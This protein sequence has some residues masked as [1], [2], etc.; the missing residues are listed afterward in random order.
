M[1]EKYFV[2]IIKSKK[3]GKN[4]IGSTKNVKRRLEWHNSG[5]NISTRYRAPF[6]IIY[7]KEFDNKKDALTYERWLKKQ[8]GGVKIKT[9]IREYN[10]P[11]IA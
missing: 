8:K 3:D 1:T 11:P 2:Y 5:R 6:V 10:I 7:S 4:Y 9:L